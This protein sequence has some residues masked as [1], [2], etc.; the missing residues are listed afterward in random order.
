MNKLLSHPLFILL[1]TLFC[2]LFWLSLYRST[3]S[4]SA[5]KQN[6]AKVKTEINFKAQELS[7]LE[8][9]YQ[10]AQQDFTKEKIARNE[11][12]LQKEGEFIVQLPPQEKKSVETVEVAT[13][14][15]WQKWK[16]LLW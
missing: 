10:T 3:Q 5:S 6:L 9:E 1:L 11:L 4:F 8:S 15:P 16:D 14:T 7:K 12:L 13:H 2:G